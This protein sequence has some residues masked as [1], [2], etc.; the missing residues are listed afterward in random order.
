M[1]YLATIHN[2]VRDGLSRSLLRVWHSG[3]VTPL[4]PRLNGLRLA[5]S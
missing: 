5:A 4:P 3:E 1:E 2:H